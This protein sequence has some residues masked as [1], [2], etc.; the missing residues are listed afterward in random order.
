MMNETVV[1]LEHVWLYYENTVALE[2]ITFQLQPLDFVSIIGPNGAGKTTLINILGRQY[3][4]SQ[5]EIFIDDILSSQTSQ[6][7]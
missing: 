7:P 1:T 3:D 6:S 4:I 2:D 5:G